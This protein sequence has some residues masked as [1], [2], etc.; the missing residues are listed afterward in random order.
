MLDIYSIDVLVI[1]GDGSQRS[2]NLARIGVP[3]I[4]IP[5][6]IDNDASTEYTIGFDT[7]MNTAME[8]ID[9]L[10]IQ[11]LLMSVAQ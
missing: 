9:K 11:H 3:V 8:A 5:G 4:G 1:G 2:K 10:R 7:A 6:T